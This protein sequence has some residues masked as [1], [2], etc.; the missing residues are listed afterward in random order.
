[1]SKATWKKM[2]LAGTPCLVPNCPDA[3]NWLS[4]T[5]LEQ[6]VLIDPRRPRNINHHRKFFALLRLA[7]ENWPV[8]ITQEALLGLIKI[9]IGHANPVQSA[10]GT[11]HYIPRSI[12]FESLDQQEF[13]PFYDSALKLIATALGVDPG[14]LNQEAHS[15]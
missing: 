2:I 1:M 15:Q 3:V 6:G 13:E 5:K 10:D 9:K 11:I 4:K 7:V 8:E 14:T 12:N